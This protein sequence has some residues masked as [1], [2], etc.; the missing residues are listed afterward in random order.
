MSTPNHASGIVASEIGV[1][2]STA[3]SLMR[4]AIASCGRETPA[5]CPDTPGSRGATI[6]CLAQSVGLGASR[7]SGAGGPV[8][9]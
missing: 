3:R 5:P 7:A 2:E 4:K 8:A 9:S 6:W 1:S